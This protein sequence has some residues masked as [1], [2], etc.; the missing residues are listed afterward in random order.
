MDIDR[1]FPN[2]CGQ[3]LSVFVGSLIGKETGTFRRSFRIERFSTEVVLVQRSQEWINNSVLLFS[4]VLTIMWN[5]SAQK[6]KKNVMIR[7]SF[8]TP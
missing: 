3:R 8:D 5:H 4:T 7:E 1:T 6:E 2:S